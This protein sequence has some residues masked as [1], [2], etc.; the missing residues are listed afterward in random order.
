MW[1]E[2][3]I[4]HKSARADASAVDHQIELAA[5]IFE[6]VKAHAGMDRTTADDKSISQIIEID[7]RVH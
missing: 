2:I 3:G 5:D 6:F 4:V 1:L 7:H